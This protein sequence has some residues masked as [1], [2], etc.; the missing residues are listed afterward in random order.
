MNVHLRH[1]G[2]ADRGLD[3][4]STGVAGCS[5]DGRLVFVVQVKV[6]ILFGDFCMLVRCRPV[7]MIRVIVTYIFVDM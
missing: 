7:V 5:L 1:V 4:M 6:M 2:T 3:R